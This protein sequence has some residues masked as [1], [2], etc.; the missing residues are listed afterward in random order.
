[1]TELQKKLAR[2]R[3]L[4]G[5][6]ESSASV[7][8]ITERMDTVDLLTTTI[9]HANSNN[10]SVNNNVASD[11]TNIG[12]VF[13]TSFNAIKDT[14]C[15][16][17]NR[18]VSVKSSSDNYTSTSS[19]MSE[20]QAKLS[21]RRT[22][23]REHDSMNGLSSDA[24]E[25][26]HQEDSIST[27]DI[28]AVIVA[29]DAV[30]DIN[31]S[32]P[33]EKIDDCN[34][35]EQVEVVLDS[36]HPVDSVCQ[37]S[38]IE[39]DGNNVTKVQEIKLEVLI[40]GDVSISTVCDGV[41]LVGGL[42]HH[43]VVCET[44]VVDGDVHS[45]HED[46]D[47]DNEDDDDEEE[48]INK[49]NLINNEDKINITRCYVENVNT[50]KQDEILSSHVDIL[51]SKLDCADDD[52]R[53]IDSSAII[54]SIG[55]YTDDDI[56]SDSIGYLEQI[57]V[58]RTTTSDIVFANIEIDSDSISQK[59][60]VKGTISKDEFICTGSKMRS[61]HHNQFNTKDNNDHKNDNYTNVLFKDGD[62]Y[63]GDDDNQINH[64]S[65]ISSDLDGVYQLLIDNQSLKQEIVKLKD[66]AVE[67]ERIKKASSKVTE[68]LLVE[69]SKC[70]D[71]IVVNESLR[72]EVSQSLIDSKNLK[73]EILKLRYLSF[74]NDDLK[75]RVKELSME[76]E[77]LKNDLS[78]TSELS[79]DNEFLKKEIRILKQELLLLKHLQNE[80]RIHQLEQES[81]E[82]SSISASSSTAV[83][84]ARPDRQTTRRFVH[85]LRYAYHSHDY[86]NNDKDGGDCD[87][88]DDD[89]SVNMFDKDK[90]VVDIEQ[91]SSNGSPIR[92]Y[93]NNNVS[94]NEDYEKTI[95]NTDT[96]GDTSA[97]NIDNKYGDKE[98]DVEHC[99][100]SS[101][102]ELS[103]DLLL[104]S[105]SGILD[106]DKYDFDE[107]K[108]SKINSKWSHK[109][110]TLINEKELVKSFISI[111]LIG[112]HNSS[113]SQN[114]DINGSESN[115]GDTESSSSSL[116]SKNNMEY[117]EFLKKFATCDDLVNFTRDFISSVL[118][119]EG[120]TSKPKHPKKLGYIFYG[121]HKLDIRCK[122]FFNQMQDI[123][124]KYHCFQGD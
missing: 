46:N 27:E 7:T 51:D 88:D 15:V 94:Y 91:L 43:A 17:P 58:D 85:S 48:E 35:E 31:V 36:D 87:D 84:D 100:S 109:A 4:N 38:T 20:L 102:N 116:S 2:R 82:V 111:S 40:D 71:L 55:K 28:T 42:A 26:I 97:T 16:S 95:L 29:D 69:Q 118:G 14:S 123:F 44:M 33:V 105:V 75:A 65:Q 1:M 96:D 101:S 60:K 72:N 77:Q 34:S 124:I 113:N 62:G 56:T 6:I 76:N 112:T 41:D 24:T 66:Y 68:Q 39:I 80:E 78:K 10:N 3:N 32:V 119:P 21:R 53:C 108:N 63:D 98:D 52:N 45:H 12:S 11:E 89:S 107:A 92:V 106:F 122:S 54:Q 64:S 110:R 23:N 30:N 79:I 9:Q 19:T 70:K 25:Y 90:N 67:N 50:I 49:S 74:E 115:Y 5:E 18:K 57:C 73:S 61:N 47:D 22:L 8:L 117:T 104:Q 121:L 93:R 114:D 103:L 120:D 99:G 86:G 13:N 37:Y 81:R 83:V 59:S